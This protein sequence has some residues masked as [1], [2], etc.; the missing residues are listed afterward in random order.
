MHVSDAADALVEL[1]DSRVQGPVNIASGE[2]LSVRE[3]VNALARYLRAENSVVLDVIPDRV[4]QPASVLAR[5]A[6]LRDEVGWHAKVS[7]IDR[8]RETCEWWRSA[9]Y[10]K[11]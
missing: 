5:I 6:R 1:F 4:G 3:V 10:S 9:N 2:A 11:E 7:S 8:M